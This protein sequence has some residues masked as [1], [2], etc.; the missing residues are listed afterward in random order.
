MVI[1]VI[2]LRNY[3]LH[4]SWNVIH[5]FFSI[6]GKNFQDSMKRENF[7]PLN[8]I[9]SCFISSYPLNGFPFVYVMHVFRT[10]CQ[11]IFPSLSNRN[12]FLENFVVQSIIELL[13]FRWLF[14]QHNDNKVS[15]YIPHRHIYVD[16]HFVLI[17]LLNNLFFSFILDICRRLKTYISRTCHYPKSLVS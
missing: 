13:P 4:F 15:F 1:N 2:N 11:F 16:F 3:G 9:L 7:S 8:R 17:I 5:S 6:E 12:Y 14:P 10:R